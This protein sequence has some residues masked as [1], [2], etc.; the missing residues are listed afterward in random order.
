MNPNKD[1][2]LEE[3]LYQA[4][5]HLSIRFAHTEELLK[6]LLTQFI[7][8]G[9]TDELIGRLLIEEYS[10]A[11][12]IEC[13]K[14]FPTPVTR[15]MKAKLDKILKEL[16]KVRQDR[17][18]FIHGLWKEPAI[19]ETTGEIQILCERKKIKYSVMADGERWQLN[20]HRL[21]KLNDIVKNTSQAEQII[22]DLESMLKELE[23]EQY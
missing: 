12:T 10:M 21:F 9:K 7:T 19:D 11:K 22:A 3:Q 20:S 5:G 13:L 14:K 4:I 17:N 15:N 23:K 1:M 6:E 18:Y 16:D 8:Q 2:S